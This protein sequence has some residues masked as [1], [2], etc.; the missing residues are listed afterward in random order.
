VIASDIG[1]DIEY[2]WRQVRRR[3]GFS[4]LAILTLAL[5]IGVATTLFTVVNAFLYKPVSGASLDTVGA[6]TLARRD[7]RGAV[8]MLF[9]SASSLGRLE[10]DLPHSVLAISSQF[11]V[12]PMV[13][14]P[15]RAQSLP[16]MCVTPGFAK[17]FDLPAQAGRWF[18]AS[19]DRG[20]SSE[21]VV[22]ISD[23]IWRGWF[24][25]D[26]SA[27][28]SA[29]L[30]LNG[31]SFRVVGVA[32][33]HFR[34]VSAG[35]EYD[36]HLPHSQ[37]YRID[38]RGKQFRE[39]AGAPVAVKARPGYSFARLAA[40][41]TGRLE[42]GGAPGTDTAAV[43]TDVR[44]RPM[45]DELRA[46]GTGNLAT[47]LL[48]IGTLVLLA[49]CANVANMLYA[50]GTE[51]SGETA[52][53]L[54]LG[55]TRGRI[56][57]QHLVEA[58]MLAFLGA[59]AGLVL[60]LVGSYLLA[61]LMPTLEL[62]RYLRL[63]LDLSPDLRVLAA[64]CCGGLAAA[65][66]IGCLTAWHA[67]RIVPLGVLASS[68]VSQGTTGRAGRTRVV[69]VSVQ[70]TVAVL[71]AMSTGLFWER[72]N[73]ELDRQK[74]RNY[75]INFDSASLVTGLVDVRLHGYS[76]SGGKYFFQQALEAVSRVPGVERVALADA[77]PGARS[78][79]PRFTMFE[80]Y[81]A[82]PPSGQL[83]RL[84]GF[85]IHVSPGFFATVGLALG[86]G[87][88]FGPS[89]AEGAPPVAIVSASFARDM[90]PNESAL[91]RRFVL[92]SLTDAG[93]TVREPVTVVGIA[94]DAVRSADTSPSQ[95]AHM[96]FLP[97]AQHYE[98]SVLVVAKSST[99]ASTYD[100]IRAALRAINDDVAIQDL[101]TARDSA[102]AWLEPLRA[103][104]LLMTTTGALA[105]GIAMLGVYGVMT[106]FVSL[107]TREIAIRLALGA[108]PRQVLGLVVAYARKVVLI[109]LLPGVWFSASGSRWIETR[110]L[111]I[112]PNE[113][114]TWIIVPL[115][116]LAAGL[117]AGYVP[118]RRASKLDPNVALRSV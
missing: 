29:T 25:G 111:D 11:A 58:S 26:R 9:P 81:A 41:L 45:V 92:P 79:G 95:P 21:P 73:Q 14:V 18:D 33:P 72:F 52:L 59:A 16:A 110:Q 35:A 107:R 1:R 28:G 39:V 87:R 10:A 89:D 64:A 46:R 57:R 103:A 83:P 102:L 19:D 55:A 30:R 13:Q 47:V 100:P 49:A 75:Y 97:L 4:S 6:V 44:I 93:A 40:D 82:V 88:D 34:G 48:G 68:N 115:L 106:Y 3:A 77:L 51:R 114:S 53:R 12:H 17:V 31:V 37:A 78:S 2:S 117:A 101:A 98:P 65:L 42:P 66:L 118:A 90:W 86:E 104:M 112:M 94:D 61:R 54:S 23:A 109:G 27:I 43:S 67:S 56:L 70:V 36:L 5:G 99:P 50:R 69:L 22:V 38:P 74:L 96:V 7:Q 15:G 60:A 80:Q 76:E 84:P 62:N 8:R 116:V 105:L 20:P 24:G 91:G 71:L 63:T 113:V 85:Y 32:A 108:T